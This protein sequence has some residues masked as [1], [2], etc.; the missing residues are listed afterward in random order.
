MLTVE[1][2]GLKELVRDLRVARERALPYA[3]KT[4]LNTAAFEGRKLWQREIKSSFTTRNSFTER[5]VL[6]ER[7]RGLDAKRMVAVLGSV[8]P[9][10]GTQEL[11]GTER[12][13]GRKK[14][15]PG[16]AAAGQAAGSKRTRLVQARARLGALKAP[17]L[18][19]KTPAQRW[20]I[21]IRKARQ[22]GHKTVLLERPKGGA[23]L[24]RVGGGKRR[25]ATLR[26]LY[27]VSRSSVRIRPEPTL[28]RTLRALEP[29]LPHMY[30]AALIDQLR[31]HKLLGY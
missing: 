3:V 11:G 15:I 12:A 23:G 31:R 24:F 14:A 8:A 30:Q 25:K 16:P 19:G 17:R 26:L 5:S 6:V 9:Y 1:F 21:A 10:M 13:R 2:R 18:I 22:D 20:A 7:A 4:A 28:Q 27:D 29:K